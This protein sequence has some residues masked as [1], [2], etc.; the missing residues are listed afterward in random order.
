MTLFPS[1]SPEDPQPITSQADSDDE[2]EGGRF[3][4]TFEELHFDSE[5]EE[6]PDL[7]LM[8]EIISFLFLQNEFS[9]SSKRNPKTTQI[10]SIIDAASPTFV[11]SIN[12][13]HVPLKL[14]FNHLYR[15]PEA[16]T[17]SIAPYYSSRL[18]LVSDL[19]IPFHS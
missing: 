17:S 7:M 12:V 2:T 14:L 16:I 8:S 6:I 19:T 5:E 11:F 9:S 15:D 4:G 18:F 10:F 13:L 3:G 1:Q